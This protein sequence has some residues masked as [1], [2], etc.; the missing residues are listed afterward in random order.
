VAEPSL[1]ASVPLQLEVARLRREL[2]ALHQPRHARRP[3]G[4]DGPPPCLTGATPAP[5]SREAA[6]RAAHAWREQL[7]RTFWD[8]PLDPAWADETV[9][10]IHQALASEDVASPTVLALECRA[11]TCRLELADDATSDLLKVLPAFLHQLAQPLPSAT[12]YRAADGQGAS[13][14]RLYLAREA[15]VPP[16]AAR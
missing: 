4:T 14:L 3:P 9:E 11:R 2:A 12:A 10:A 1:P 16:R 7:E 15:P 13:S 5:A 8:E 6:H